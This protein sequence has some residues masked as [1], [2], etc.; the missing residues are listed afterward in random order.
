MT[1]DGHI[2]PGLFDFLIELSENNDRAWF[3]ENR[4]RYESEVK[5]PLLRFVEDFES[6]LHA[7]SPHFIADARP[8]GGSM[9]RIYRDVRFSR[10]K[11]PYKTNA[12]V[13]FRHEVGRDVHAPG[14]Y[15]HFEPMTAFGGGGIWH[16]DS[17]TLGKIRGAITIDPGRWE[18][19]KT[20]P[21]LL[22]NHVLGGDSL[23][24]PPRGYDADHPQIEDIKKKDFVVSASYDEEE[25]TR[26]DF[27]DR[28]AADCA[29]I[30]PF[31]RFMTEAVGLPF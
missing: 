11:S 9:F 23:K 5:G 4:K 3:N 31:M 21:G 7:I 13:H 29:A 24:R 16:P 26:P 27:I 1:G 19:V 18:E 12:G 8:A 17:S 2:G 25:M 20:D 28:Y 30:S 10:D 15:L 22:E 14:Y 6:R